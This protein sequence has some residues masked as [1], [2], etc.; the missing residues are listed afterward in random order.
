MKMLLAALCFAA[1][2]CACY[3]LQHTVDGRTHGA[4]AEAAGLLGCAV[5][6]G[7]VAWKMK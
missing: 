3:V 7:A 1:G 5:V 6:A 4:G 2:Y